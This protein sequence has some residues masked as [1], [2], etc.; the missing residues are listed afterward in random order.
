[1][2][3]KTARLETIELPDFGMPSSMPVLPDELYASRTER[4]RA[5]AAERGY[6][7]LV[8]YADREH[9]AN[10][11]YLTGF[12]PRFEEA[13]LILGSAGEPLALVGNECQGLARAAPLPMRVELFQ[14]LSLPGQPRDRSRPLAEILASEGIAPGARVGVAGW[15]PFADRSWLEVPAYLADALRAAVGPGGLVENANDLFVDAS[16]GLRAVN[17]VEQLAAFEYAACQTSEGVK[18]LLHGLRPGMTEHEAARLF[19][20]S[21]DPLSCHFML[22]SGVRASMGMLS[23]SDRVIERGD[24]FTTAF[25]IW[26]A[27]DCR[28]GFVVEDAA[29]LPAGIADYVERLVAPYF[30]AIAE[31]LEALHVGQTGG[32]LQAIVDRHLGDPFFGIFL[33]PGHLL[34]LDEWVNSPIARGSTIELRSGMALQVDVIPATGTDYFTTNIEGGLAIADAALRDDIE[35]RFPEAWGRIQARRRFM[36]EALGIDLHPDVLPFSNLPAFLPPF[37]LRPDRAMT[38]RLS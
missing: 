30:L 8:V 5:R 36:R 12:D 27:L 28:A 24:R 19:G 2:T 18:R 22:S 37:L 7:S 21:G 1:M 9:S 13:V 14:D 35:A 10:L 25:G 23:P 11:A 3:M 26:G 15:K 33:N 17:E 16:S 6:D 38:V 31:W 29:E 32:A 4:A 34:G 20:W